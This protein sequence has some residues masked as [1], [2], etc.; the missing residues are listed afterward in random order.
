MDISSL[1]I[2]DISEVKY[3]KFNILAGKQEVS[4][5]ILLWYHIGNTDIVSY[6]K[7]IEGAYPY[8]SLF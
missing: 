4:L 1:F 5:K 6:H 8:I 7:K 3:A 2:S